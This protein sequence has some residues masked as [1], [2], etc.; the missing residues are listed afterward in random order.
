[1]KIDIGHE[2]AVKNVSY[3]LSIQLI[4]SQLFVEITTLKSDKITQL[5]DQNGSSCQNFRHWL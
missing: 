4:F 1:M 5:S 2:P 3:H